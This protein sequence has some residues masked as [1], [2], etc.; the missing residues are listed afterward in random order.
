MTTKHRITPT[1][2]IQFLTLL[3]VCL[4]LPSFAVCQNFERYRPKLPSNLEGESKLPDKPAEATGDPKILVEELKGVIFVD[5]QDKV[6]AGAIEASGVQ[7][8]SDGGLQM[9]QTLCF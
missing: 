5:H 8:R 9:L 4:L 7:V 6:I 2:T 3:A 1:G